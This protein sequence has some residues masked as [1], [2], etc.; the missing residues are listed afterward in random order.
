LVW[1]ELQMSIRSVIFSAALGAGIMA[2][3]AANAATVDVVLRSNSIDTSFQTVALEAGTW[4]IGLLASITG[5]GFISWNPWGMTSGCVSSANC[6]RGWLNDFRIT[7][8]DGTSVGVNVPR[9]A[10]GTPELARNNFKPFEFVLGQAGDVV[11]SISDGQTDVG[12]YANNLGGLS[13]RLTLRD[14]PPPPPPPTTNPSVIP[15][16]AGGVLLLSAFGLMGWA[17]WYRRAR[18]L[19][20]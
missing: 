17:S 7:T 4:D 20:A 12:Q 15:L 16:P 8:S 1:S 14:A 9:V 19:D 18:H 3:G 2:H 5:L 13:L 10:Y 11:F 6:T